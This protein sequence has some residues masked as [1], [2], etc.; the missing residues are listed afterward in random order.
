MPHRS[1]ET[2]RM[3]TWIDLGAR[4]IGTG[5]P[6]YVVA[7]IS[8]NHGQSLERAIEIVHA[9]R[10][11]GADAVKLQTYTP[12]T[13]T[14]PIDA[15]P[16]RIQG[17]MWGGR[18]LFDLYAEA[19][20]PWEWHA[21][22]KE[23]ALASGL[24]LFSTPFDS[25]SVD[26]L[27]EL[28]VP[29]YK[30][31]SF[32]LVDLPLLRRVS[33]TGKPIIVS[34]GMATFAE[35]E[36]AV[37]TIRDAGGSSLALLKCTSAYPASPDEANLRTIPALIEAF[38]VPVGLSD[39]SLGIGVPV[40]AVALGACIVEKHLTLSRS[41]GG[42]DAAFSLEPAE[43]KSTVD[44]IRTASAATG[45]VHFGPSPS[46]RASLAFRRSLFAVR[47]IKGGEAFS[48]EN[49][50]A[51]RPGHGLHPRYVPV[52]VGRLATRDIPIG[53][54]LSWDLISGGGPAALCP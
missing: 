15:E 19:C 33:A 44:A 2:P 51:I 10:D 45:T 8:A 39:H 38:G 42:P 32:E 43:F 14:L 21:R 40:A 4:R 18:R 23:V 6:V 49:V 27:A 5:Y 37:T 28:G 46:E 52:I 16:F 1:S 26:F 36:E 48:A 35:I 53:T 29:A 30:I 25:S 20:T 12:E 41:L 9:A 17:T 34:T 3:P 31:A 13:M 22:L 24:D 54:P 50:R 47:D 7:E 11:A